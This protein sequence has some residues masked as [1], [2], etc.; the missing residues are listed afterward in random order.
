MRNVRVLENSAVITGPLAASILADLGADVL[1]V[2]PPSGDQF[3]KWSP[4]TTTVNPV[5]GCINR[6]KQSVVLDLKTPSGSKE[7][8]RL[9]ALADVVIENFRPGVMDGLNLGYESIRAVNPSIVYCHITGQ[10]TNPTVASKPTFDA[11]A[12]ALSGLWSQL[13]D[14]KDPQPVG[15]PM[16]DSLTSLY[17]AIAVLGALM[18]TKDDGVGRL[19]QINMVET[20]MAFQSIAIA[21]MHQSGVAPDAM[22][23]AHQ[24]QTYALVDSNGESFAIHLSTPLKFWL[25]LCNAFELPHLHDDEALRTKSER[26][27]RYDEIAAQ[28]RA[29]ACTRP[30]AEWIER[31]ESQDVP[32][33]AILDLPGAVQRISQLEP[34][35]FGSSSLDPSQRVPF[36]ARVDGDYLRSA[37]PAP[38]LGAALD[39]DW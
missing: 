15:P 3:R 5:F 18:S 19:I 24:S 27:S 6:G 4:S 10:G 36:P 14:I 9:A 8:L 2:E 33:S 30:R 13:S 31:L 16:A 11:I 12:Q 26:I 23:R 37:R 35:F 22:T 25:G 28:L 21:T 7:Y 17:A 1:K 29:I 38:A 32:A 34:G 20:C 39:H